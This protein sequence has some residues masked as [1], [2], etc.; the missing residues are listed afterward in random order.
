MPMAATRVID[1]VYVV[2]MGMARRLIWVGKRSPVDPASFA[3]R[4]HKAAEGY[5]S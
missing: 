1:G 2:P 3:N 4:R 5:R